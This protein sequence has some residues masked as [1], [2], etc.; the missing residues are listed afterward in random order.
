MTEKTH[1]KTQEI[2]RTYSDNRVIESDTFKLEVANC[3]K[4]LSYDDNQ[5]LWVGVEHCHW[6]HTFDSNGR[7]MDKCNSVSGH[8]HDIKYGVDA[9]GNLTAK[10]SPCVSRNPKDVHA[11]DITYIKSDKFKVRTLDPRAVEA[12]SKM[13]A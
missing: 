2:K 13:D 5:P 8:H 7:K 3:M 10:C 12:M 11:H 6:F 4:N 9:K 1:E